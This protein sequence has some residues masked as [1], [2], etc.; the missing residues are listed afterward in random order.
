MPNIGSIFTFH[1]FDKELSELYISHTIRRFA[2]AMVIIFEPIYLFLYFDK[3]FSAVLLFF[4]SIALLYGLF[5]P[6]GAKIMVK[7]GL[8]KAMLFSVPLLFL[9]YLVLWQI[10]L[11]PFFFLL[12]LALR[13]I[14]ALF[15]WPAYHTDMARSSKKGLRGEQVG[16]SLVVYNLASVIGPFIGGLL[17]FELGFPILFIVVLILLLVSVVPLFFSKEIHEVYTDSYKKAFR[18]IFS[19]KFYKESIAFAAFGFD[20]G[21]SFFIW[22]IFMFVLAINYESMGLITSGALFLSLIFTLY[23]GKLVDRLSRRR[24]LRIGSILTA[25]AWFF[26]TFI[27]TPLDAFLAHT[28]YRFAFTSS[29]VPYRAIMYDKASE[30]KRF[31]DRFIVFREMSHNL[32]R[33]LIFIILAIVFFFVPVS[34]IYLIF[35]L[36]AIFALFFMLLGHENEPKKVSKNL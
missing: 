30:D 36:A 14:Y 17:V 22:P 3:S 33:A 21:V 31:I 23:I 11:F 28:I 35:P 1:H 29:N 19:R 6:F 10:E 8:K 7:L 34:K 2:L 26:K 27:R 25:A 20:Q 32:G 5:V 15:Y 9:Y 24:L 16:A 12:A 13:V 4:A 18:Q